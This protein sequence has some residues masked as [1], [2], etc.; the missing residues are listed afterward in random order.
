MRLSGQ[1]ALVLLLVTLAFTPARRLLV[2]ASHRVRRPH[3]RR[4]S[5]W[6]ALVALRR[7]VG[8]LSFF[9]A[10]LHLVI[11]AV[12]DAGLDAAALLEDLRQRP[13]IAA[14]M[15]VWLLLAPLAATSNRRAM[16]AL[17]RRW[18]P[19]HR[20]V[21]LALPLAVAHDWLQARTAAQW[22]WLE[23]ALAA[24]LLASRLWTWRR[25]DSGVPMPAR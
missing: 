12:F 3:G 13:F 23:A 18:R 21:Y 25:S 20:L 4:P 15:G 7:P 6:N 22:P 11:Y 19:L 8:L 5:D 1:T 24:L 10:C 9:Y 16:K 14:G 2:A 17:G